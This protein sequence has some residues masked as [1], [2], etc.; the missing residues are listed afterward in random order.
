M[1]I[2][3]VEKISKSQYAYTRR[4]FIKSETFE[5][6]NES[7]QLFP[8]TGAGGVSSVR[9]K[10][11]QVMFHPLMS[12]TCSRKNGKKKSQSSRMQ[13][14]KMEIHILKIRTCPSIRQHVERKSALRPSLCVAN[15][16]GLHESA[17]TLV[18]QEFISPSYSSINLS[19]KF[20]SQHLLM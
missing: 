9:G 16:D 11:L 8:G 2:V 3:T 14:T 10:S 7:I 4:Y 6:I 5:E 19:K 1:S 20:G 15:A 12:R 18:S 13:K 17:S